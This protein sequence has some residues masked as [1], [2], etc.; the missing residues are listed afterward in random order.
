M[1]GCCSVA[2]RY[3]RERKD[4]V[5]CMQ[6]NPQYSR[7][8]EGARKYNSTGDEKCKDIGCPIDD[9]IDDVTKHLRERTPE[10]F[11]F[12][13]EEYKGPTQV[14]RN[15]LTNYYYPLEHPD[16]SVQFLPSCG[17]PGYEE[18]E[19]NDAIG[20]QEKKNCEANTFLQAP[21]SP[22]NV[23]NI[24]P[25]LPTKNTHST[26][27]KED[28][29]TKGKAGSLPFGVMGTVEVSRCNQT[30]KSLTFTGKHE[31]SQSSLSVVGCDETA[32]VAFDTRRRSDNIVPGS[33]NIANSVVTNPPIPKAEHSVEVGALDALL[34][35]Q[36]KNCQETKKKSQVGCSRGQLPVTAPENNGDDMEQKNVTIAV[37][38]NPN[39]GATLSTPVIPTN[40]SSSNS[41]CGLVLEANESSADSSYYTQDEL[42][43]R[44]VVESLKDKQQS[45]SFSPSAHAKVGA[46]NMDDNAIAN[47]ID[48]STKNVMKGL[49]ADGNSTVL[50]SAPLFPPSKNLMDTTQVSPASNV[51]TGHPI[52]MAGVWQIDS[53]L[54]MS[55]NGSGMSCVLPT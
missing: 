3:H 7:F 25:S 5:V 47:I 32:D 23:N 26:V 41:N 12:G 31:L 15:P 48:V 51:G 10:L 53:L 30:Q 29:S 45:S 20:I 54:L 19:Y 1:S 11:L 33:W 16:I 35:K 14:R 22:S 42:R 49:L 27:E 21:I 44:Q 50:S 17:D 40:F 55:E 8:A 18:G 13:K 4:V 43:E 37:N 2:A 52:E 38:M 24:S 46:A 6:A 39:G 36:I 28:N 34:E 9:E